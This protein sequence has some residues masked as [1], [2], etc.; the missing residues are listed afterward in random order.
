MAL[1]LGLH[2]RHRLRLGRC[3]WARAHLAQ[4][5]S[6]RR[7]L[8]ILYGGSVTPENAAALLEVSGA[9]GFLI[10]GASLKAASFV[11]IAGLGG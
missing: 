5:L 7:E 9:D 1:G 11:A 6:D 3:V 4:L 10:G 2:A 8:R